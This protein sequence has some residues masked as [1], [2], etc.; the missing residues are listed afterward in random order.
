MMARIIYNIHIS[1]VIDI[2]KIIIIPISYLFY[3][4][5]KHLKIEIKLF[6]KISI[7]VK[8]LDNC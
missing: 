6:I 3:S 1:I 2:F 4:T 7:L 8:I 5:N